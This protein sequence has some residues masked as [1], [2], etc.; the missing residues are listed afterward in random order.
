MQKYGP[1]DV[2]NVIPH[3]NCRDIGRLNVEVQ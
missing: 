3:A 1:S 2:V